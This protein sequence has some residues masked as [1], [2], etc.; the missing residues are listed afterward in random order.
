MELEVS[1]W[2]YVVVGILQLAGVIFAAW[3]AQGAKRNATEANRAV[4]CTKPGSPRIYDMVLDTKAQVEH[5]SQW[6]GSYQGGPLDRGHK[7]EEF[8]K[9]VDDRFTDVNRH[10][11][12]RLDAISASIADLDMK[13][14]AS[15]CPYRLRQGGP[16][17]DTEGNPKQE[18]D[19]GGKDPA[20]RTD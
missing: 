20:D 3:L 14:D 18:I 13:V 7:V 11:D 6:M 4:N 10:M 16:L 9:N 12:F 19:N 5:V 17:C 8:V 2:A 1:G 15:G